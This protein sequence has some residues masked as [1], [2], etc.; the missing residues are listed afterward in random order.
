MLKQALLDTQNS[1]T[2]LRYDI[3]SQ[4]PRLIK[5]GWILKFKD[6]I[7]D[8]EVDIM[9]NKKAEVLHSNMILEY[10]RIGGL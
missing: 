1:S 3:T 8:I 6:T 7:L 5:P 2:S 4:M 9:V 10:S